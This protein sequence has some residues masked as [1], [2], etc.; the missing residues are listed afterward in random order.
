MSFSIRLPHLCLTNSVSINVLASFQLVSLSLSILQSLD[1]Y[2]CQFLCFVFRYSDFG[3]LEVAC[4]P[5]VPKFAGS[6]PAE[7]FGF[8]GRIKILSTPSC[9]GVV[10]PSVPCLSFT[11]CKRSLNVTWKSTFRQNFR[12]F[13]THSS[14]SRRWVLSRGDAWW[15][16]LKGLT[17]IA[18]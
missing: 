10:K 6:H 12:T 4:W 9:V 14:T 8:L 1:T 16:K 2:I 15:R 13:L 11:A 17:Q 7:V 18:Q 5:L 3:A